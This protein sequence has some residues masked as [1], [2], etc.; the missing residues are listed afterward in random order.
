MNAQASELLKVLATAAVTVVTAYQSITAHLDATVASEVQ[1][2]HT[3]IMLDIRDDLQAQREA[4]LKHADSLHI[5]TTQRIEALEAA[6]KM[7]RDHIP[8]F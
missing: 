7:R 6:A 5:L 8:G 3:A 1:Q 2:M 4:I